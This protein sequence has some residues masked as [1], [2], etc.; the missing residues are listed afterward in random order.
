[1]EK[2]AMVGV[3]VLLLGLI[4]FVWKVN[5]D[6]QYIKRLQHQCEVVLGGESFVIADKPHLCFM[7]DGTFSVVQDPGK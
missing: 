2:P 5:D 7:P 1:M 6:Q 4:L 3:I